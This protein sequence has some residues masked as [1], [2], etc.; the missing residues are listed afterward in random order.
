MQEQKQ[1]LTD[2]IKRELSEQ[3]LSG[4][5]PGGTQIDE[6]MLVKR[7]G[8]SRTPAREALLQLAATGLVT[9]IP[10]QGA[11][12]SSISLRE[13]VGLNEV[14]AS[15]ESL[16]AGLAARRITTEETVVLRH[17]YEECDAAASQSDPA[18]YRAANTRFHTTIYDA[19]RNDYLNQQLRTLRARM[20]SII[21]IRFERPA[22][23]RASLKEHRDILEAILAGDEEAASKA[24][25]SH[26]SAGANN[27]A[28]ML[29]AFPNEQ[30]TL[31][32]T[33]F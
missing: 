12:V 20:R 30:S 9:L 27:F 25:A 3:I 2:T 19:C 24:M 28:D 23:M 33:I 11:V 21:D 32:S 7:F 10:R 22:R 17:S 13:Y 16:A 6:Q 1:N 26:I 15:L 29:A 31:T 14:L 4:A 8:V 5:L 18:A